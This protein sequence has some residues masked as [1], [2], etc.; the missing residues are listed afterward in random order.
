MGADFVPIKDTIAA[1]LLKVAFSFYFILAVTVT[2]AHI[3]AEYVHTRSLVLRELEIL[4]QTFRPTLQQALWEMNNNQL[5]STLTGIMRLPNIV[6]IEI[7]NHKGIYLGEMGEVLHLSDS[8]ITNNMDTNKSGIFFSSGLFCKTFQ[9]NHIR[10][11]ISFLVGVVTI[12]S[13]RNVVIDKLKFSAT[14]L[15]INAIIKIIGFWILFLLISRSL[16]SR[17]LAEFTR[18]A[19][20]LQLDNLEN[21]KIDIH[22]KG[23]NELK[24]LENAFK[25]MIRNLLQTRTELYKNKERVEE[26]TVELTA[27]NEQLN[28]ENSE[29]KRA[30][31]TLRESEER[32]RSLIRKVQAAIVLHDGQGRILDSN[33]MARYLLGLSEDQLLGK[34]LI[35]PEWHFLR[36]DGSVLPVAEYPVSRVLS[37]RQPLRGYVSGISRPDRDD[38][39]WVLVNAEPEYGNTGEINRVIV[40]FVDITKR[41]QAEKDNAWNLAINQALSS[42]Y[43]PLV[44][45]GTD[46]EKIA[47][48]VLEKCRQLT[49][50]PH[51]FVAEIDQANGDLIAHTNTKMLQTEC[52]IAEEKLRKVRF[53][54]RADGL[55]NGLWGHALNT[56]EPFYTDVPVKHPAS[57][58]VPEGHVEIERFLSV[59]VLLAGELV[60]QIALSNSTRAYTDQDL[61]TINRITEFFALAIQHKRAEEQILNL[62]QELEQRVLERTTQLETANKELEAFAYSVSHD[63]R[64]PLRGIDGFS[65][66]L[67]DEYQDRMDEQGKKYLQRVRSAAHHM[68][69]L[70]DDMLNLS[71]VGRIDMINQQVNLS[72]IA[73]EITEDLYKTDPERQVVF[74]MPEGIKAQGDGQLLRIVLDNLIRNAWKFTS[75]H[76]KA[77]I[78]FGL[79]QEKEPP[80][81]FIRDDGAGFDMKYA[82]KMFGVFQ[83]L[84]TAYEFAGTGVG[85]ATA[86][87][88]I[89]RH[90]GKI[91]AQG[92]V[93]KGAVFYF[94]IKKGAL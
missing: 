21:V 29:R 55:Y 87:R 69:Q 31:E 74:V 14:I 23:N 61:D 50:S 84:H 39:A 45:A 60:G 16:L 64:A 40:S 17:P 8:A 94:T 18:A 4:A 11:D 13:S 88:I 35:D 1:R 3:A 77:R 82:D 80:V 38:V 90:G 83:R 58:G 9:I 70:I 33:P 27:A 34:T 19:E 93:E 49:G 22:T 5:Q 48:I 91:W 71:R 7:V 62:N 56:K 41:K 81:Y 51:G 42:L 73:R 24:I 78:E 92:E 46:I 26:R 20:Q 15:I 79:Q 67:L 53:P 10:G 6:G 37:T 66:I 76:P 59:P 52:K 32:Y 86:Q 65:Q 68:A 72:D 89:H 25:G 57:V 75:K 63:L 30:E 12:Y 85:L 36:E 47:T 28:I 43:I 2:V 54:Q 44:T